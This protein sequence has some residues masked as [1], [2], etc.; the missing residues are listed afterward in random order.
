[1]TTPSANE[2]GETP[3]PTPDAGTTV[4]DQDQ[5][6]VKQ[7]EKIVELFGSY[8]NKSKDAFKNFTDIK[9]FASEVMKTWL[10]NAASGTQDPNAPFYGVTTKAVSSAVLDSSANSARILVTTKREEITE[11][12]QT[13]RTFYALIVVDMLKEGDEWKVNGLYWQ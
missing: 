2:N 6:I 13:P 1:T 3:E 11:Q 10:D 8:T 7:A 5:V 9:P 12:N 4:D